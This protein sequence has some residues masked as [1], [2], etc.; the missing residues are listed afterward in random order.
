MILRREFP[1]R[2]GNGCR[3][4]KRRKIARR[5]KIIS[6]VR[7]SKRLWHSRHRLCVRDECRRGPFGPWLTAARCHAVKDMNQKWCPGEC[8]EERANFICPEVAAEDHQ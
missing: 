3:S 2:N 8:A 6:R 4:S 7:F 1:G 5:S